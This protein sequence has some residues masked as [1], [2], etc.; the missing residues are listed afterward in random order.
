MFSYDFE[1]PIDEILFEPIL[2]VLEWNHDFMVFSRLQVHE[3]KFDIWEPE[4]LEH[5]E[6]EIRIRILYVAIFF[7]LGNQF[8]RL[9]LSL[10]WFEFG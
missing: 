7:A 6:R 9:V 10:G 2:D 8:S 1:D 3:I 5:L 4:P